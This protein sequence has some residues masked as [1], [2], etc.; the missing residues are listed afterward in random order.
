MRAETLVSEQEKLRREDFAKQNAAAEHDQHGGED[1]R[2]RAVAAVFAATLAI[3]VEDSD[4]RDGGCTADEEVGE[5]VGKLE[6]GLV[7][8]LLGTGAP[9]LVDDLDADQTKQA[10]GN[11]AAHQQDG[12]GAC[13]VLFGGGARGWGLRG[14]QGRETHR[15]RTILRGKRCCDSRANGLTVRQDIFP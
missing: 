5:Q 6:G 2:E 9:E 11:G 4:E 8:V 12:C 15:A 10:R 14:G 7:G 1:D 3:A 13:G